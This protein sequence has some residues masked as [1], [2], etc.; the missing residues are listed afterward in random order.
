MYCRFRS[1]YIKP[2]LF[3]ILILPS[4]F[5]HLSIESPMSSTTS[6]SV[7]LWYLPTYLPTYLPACACVC[8]VRCSAHPSPSSRCP[9]DID[10]RRVA[11][12]VEL[13]SRGMLPRHSGRY[14]HNTTQ[15]YVLNNEPHPFYKALK[16][17]G[18]YLTSTLT[19]PPHLPA[20]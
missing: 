16:Q 12:D 17:R 8:R 15:R 7:P 10:K 9:Q 11:Q 18:F 3:L 19:P 6:Q 1:L 14:T 4:S 2:L 5:L 20:P 13:Y